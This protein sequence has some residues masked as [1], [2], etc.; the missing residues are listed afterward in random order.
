MTRRRSQ[1]WKEKVH[2]LFVE[3]AKVYREAAEAMDAL[4]RQ[5]PAELVAEIGTRFRQKLA[6]IRERYAKNQYTPTMADPYDIA[7]VNFGPSTWPPSEQESNQAF[8]EHLHW[9]RF[10]EPLW[11]A[12][13]KQNGGDLDALR[14]VHRTI[15]DYERLRFGKGPIKAAK[16]D[17][18][19][20][21]L[22]EM[23]LDMGLNLMTA[24]ELAD[25]FDAVCPCGKTHDADALKKQR[26]RRLKAIQDARDWLV[27][28]RAKMSSNEWMMAYGKHGLCAFSSFS[29]SV[30]TPGVPSIGCKPR[31]VYVGNI[32]GQ[33]LCYIN[34]DGRLVTFRGSRF[35]RQ[36]ASRKLPAAFGVKTMKEL[37]TMFFPEH[38]VR[39]GKSVNNAPEPNQTFLRSVLTHNQGKRR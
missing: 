11:I 20:A 32:G 23:G 3:G 26:S 6:E 15:E 24:E 30:A 33:P 38:R 18:E 2:P 31:R 36:S 21:A 9:R 1:S 34:E 13:Q 12:L 10:R 16:G 29:V 14:R 17:A 27:A 4:G 7:F 22:F 5:S 25:C 28:E 37:F 8:L 19:H 35:A 39:S